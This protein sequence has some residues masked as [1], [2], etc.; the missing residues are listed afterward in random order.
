MILVDTSIWADH[1]RASDPDLV[2]LIERR[3]VMMHRLVVEEL[4]MGH[5]PQR[6]KTLAMLDRLPALPIEQAG[7]LISFVDSAKLV[8]A[9][10]G[11]V[12]AHLILSS[13]AH[14]A[15]LWTRDKGLS[16]HAERLGCAWKP[17]SPS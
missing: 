13:V 3:E 1:F 11:L 7:A 10:I 2:V 12:D 5:L 14:G 4:A 9:G 16:V 17:G 8:G 15:A 6:S